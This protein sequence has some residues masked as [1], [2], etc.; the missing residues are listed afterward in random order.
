MK[1]RHQAWQ[2]IIMTAS[3]LFAATCSICRTEYTGTHCP[4]CGW[5]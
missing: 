2:Q 3:R 5:F 1:R 4:N